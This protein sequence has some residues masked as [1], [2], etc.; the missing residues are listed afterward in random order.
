MAE[1]SQGL[2]SGAEQLQ[3][4]AKGYTPSMSSVVQDGTFYRGTF[5]PS[6]G[7]SGDIGSLGG[8][9]IDEYV[10]DL[11][12][13]GPWLT[14]GTAITARCTPIFLSCQILKIKQISY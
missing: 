3:N 2:E 11:L 1:G 12:S 14:R 10:K 13:V 6:Q 7:M 4:F 9:P 5:D 8:E